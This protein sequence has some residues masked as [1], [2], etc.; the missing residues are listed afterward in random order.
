MTIQETF[1]KLRDDFKEWVRNNFIAH[2]TKPNIHTPIVEITKEEY[3]KLGDAVLNDGI[4]YCV[5]DA[6]IDMSAKG[7]TYD[8][9]KTGY[10]ANNVQDAIDE[11]DVQ[12]DNLENKIA[13]EVDVKIENIEQ[14]LSKLVTFEW[15]EDTQT[16]NIITQ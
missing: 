15:D 9:S 8:N 1:E 6:E 7:I 13:D 2:V 5:K 16:L 12:M 10:T 14:E 11:I 4:I 3:A